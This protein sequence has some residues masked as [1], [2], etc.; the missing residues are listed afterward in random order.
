MIPYSYPYLPTWHI[1][2]LVALIAVSCILIEL[3]DRI[4]LQ[5]SDVAG[6]RRKGTIEG[7]FA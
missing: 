7:M 2:R 5:T 1:D 6:D 4:F 3:T